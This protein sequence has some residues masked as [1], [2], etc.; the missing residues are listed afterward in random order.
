MQLQCCQYAE[1]REI[2][3]N[4]VGGKKRNRKKSAQLREQT[5]G[6]LETDDHEE[7]REEAVAGKKRKTTKSNELEK[8]KTLAAKTKSKK[9]ET[10]DKVVQLES[11]Q[12][13]A[14][15]VIAAMQSSPATAEKSS[16][17][18]IQ[19]DEPLPI[20]PRNLTSGKP[21]SAMNDKEEV[22]SYPSPLLP[23]K[24]PTSSHPQTSNGNSC[25]TQPYSSSSPMGR[26]KLTFLHNSYNPT[27]RPARLYSEQRFHIDY[28]TS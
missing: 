20:S 13:M 16:V 22:T 24:L 26:G 3:L 1:K 25:S 19:D 5:D 27:A 21:A 14:R 6:D 4:N 12:I 2:E 17:M 8:S 9:K 23:P 11:A 10:T 18:I 7:N 28:Y 15:Q